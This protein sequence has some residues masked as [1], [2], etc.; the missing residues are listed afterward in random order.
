MT[1]PLDKLNQRQQDVVTT[2]DRPLLVLAGA[3]SGKTRCVI[4]RAAY[5]LNEINIHPA[6]I[7]IVTFTNKAARE[8]KTRLLSNF[9]IDP[10]MMWVG[11]FHSICVRMLRAEEENL[12]FNR[13]FVIYDMTDQRSLLKRIVK[14]E[15][16]DPRLATDKFRNKISRL[17]SS[18]ITPETFWDFYP[19]NPNN[20]EIHKIFSKYN[21][22]LLKA[23]ALDFDDLLLYTAKLL[24]DNISVREKY[25]SRFQHIMVDEYQDT[26]YAQFR[27][28]NLLAENHGNLCVVG[29]DDQSIYSW[30]GATIKNILHFEKDYKNVKAVKL[31]QNYRSTQPILSIANQLI[32]NN[33]E[34]HSKVLW[35][36]NKEGSDPE[37]HRYENERKESEAVVDRILELRKKKQIPLSQFAVLYRTNAQS[38][39]IETACIS[40]GIHYQVVGGV[41][42]YARREIKDIIAYLKVISN[43]LDDVSLLRIINVPTRKIGNTSVNKLLDYA[44]SENISFYNAILN[45]DKIDTLTKGFKKRIAD[46]GNMMEKWRSD[47]KSETVDILIGDIVNT[48]GFYEIYKESDDPQDNSRAENILGLLSDIQE[49][50]R[51]REDENPLLL[52]EYLNTVAL[53]SDLDKLDES[54]DVINLITMHNAKGL[55]F[56]YV[57]VVGLNDG[58]LP[59]QRSIQDIFGGEESN[60]KIEEERRLLYVA[61]TRARKELFMSYTMIR[62]IMNSN[63]YVRPSRFIQE[64][65]GNNPLWNRNSSTI[66]KSRKSSTFQSINKRKN[67]ILESQKSY[68]IGNRVTHKTFGNGTILSVDGV[69]LDTKLTVSFD[70]GQLKHIVGS[71]VTIVT[72]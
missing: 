27:I 31:E 51:N 42:F 37:L 3:G 30:R 69:G 67:V 1:F 22:S 25:A 2:V 57:F 13:N 23:N 9:G 12:P 26:N 4:Y 43:P 65:S 10:R 47:S 16:L 32:Q 28:V 18:L 72:K 36:E 52:S 7:L 24:H 46:F 55:E 64:M 34:R 63:D 39:S 20:L 29:D 59:H 8:L 19:Q 41:D 58:V 54:V 68:Q 66:G 53:Q 45:V 61:I 71:Y 70:T 50:S 48:L 17:K 14:T 60:E 38:R 49:L 40:A 5:L 15:K 11:T 56:D 62:R 21:S 6:N 33:A 35:T 44:I